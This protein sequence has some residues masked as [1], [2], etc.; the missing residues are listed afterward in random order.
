MVAQSG[1]APPAGRLSGPVVK[2]Q[3]R[4]A[5]KEITR[6]AQ[7]AWVDS[8]MQPM[9][10]SGKTMRTTCASVRG[11]SKTTDTLWA[12][13]TSP[14]SERP[15]DIG[16]SRGT[17]SSAGGTLSASSMSGADIPLPSSRSFSTALQ[18]P[19]QASPDCPAVSFIDAKRSSPRV[20]EFPGPFD[21]N[22]SLGASRFW[23]RSWPTICPLVWLTLGIDEPHQKLRRR[24]RVRGHCGNSAGVDASSRGTRWSIQRVI[25]S[26]YRVG[27]RSLPRA[28]VTIE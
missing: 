14:P 6:S 4:P 7:A 9:K 16:C 27:R 18:N 3:N 19:T 2:S 13:V 8:I 20:L 10:K 1:A 23:R 11:A 25:D 21:S 26:L 12:R 28:L 24:R 22:R 5:I 17:E 15:G